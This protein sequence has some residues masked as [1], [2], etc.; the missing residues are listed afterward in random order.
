MGKST[1]K[2]YIIYER[3]EKG[4]YVASAPAIPGC[5]VYGKTLQEAHKN[6]YFAIQDCLDTIREFRQ[7]PPKETVKPETV[8]KLS[9][10]SVPEYAKT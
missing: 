3:D 6:I 8:K 4:G 7:R 9:F 5:V 10:I 1:N 2:Y